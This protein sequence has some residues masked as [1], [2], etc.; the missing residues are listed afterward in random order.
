MDIEQLKLVLET[1]SGMTDGAFY[2][3]MAYLSIL[4]VKPIILFA[5]LGVLIWVLINRAHSMYKSYLASEYALYR[6]LRC[7]YLPHLAHGELTASEK[8]KIVDRLE[9][10]LKRLKELDNNA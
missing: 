4:I 8:H 1:V 10:D 7:H 3:A 2:V 9:E 6:R 5:G